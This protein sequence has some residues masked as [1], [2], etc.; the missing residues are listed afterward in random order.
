MDEVGMGF[1]VPSQAKSVGFALEQ[2]QQEY[3]ALPKA[4]FPWEHLDSVSPNP[5]SCPTKHLW[6][7]RL[8]GDT[9]HLQSC[10]IAPLKF[11]KSSQGCQQPCP[12]L[13]HFLGIL[14]GFWS[15]WKPG[16]P[17][18]EFR[19]TTAKSIPSDSLGLDFPKKTQNSRLPR[20]CFVGFLSPNSLENEGK[21]TPK[22]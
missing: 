10:H 1:K 22:L 21:K 12:I 7:P 3:L 18:A 17:S 13:H 19:A 16:T 2:Q 5:G 15:C 20:E 14:S 6:N 9:K 11:Q 4:S 8:G